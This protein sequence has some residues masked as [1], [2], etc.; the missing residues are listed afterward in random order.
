MSKYEAWVDETLPKHLRLTDSVV[1]IIEN[2]LKT[3]EIDY[4]TVS[5]RTK[6][7]ESILEKIERKAYKDPAKQLTDLTGIRVVGYFESDISK[8]SD[9]IK[10]AFNVDI[11]NSLN[12]DEKLSVNQIGYRSVHFVCDIGQTR[13][14]LPE[15]LNLS[16]LK[17]E[18][19][20]RTVLQHAWAE[21]AHDR[22][23][24]FS[25][26]LP[27]EIER[28]LF[29]YAG[30][31]EIA[32][33]GFNEISKKIDSY[34]EKVQSDTIQ[35]NLDYI[36]D[37]I[38]LPQF[39]ENW[40]KTNGLKLEPLKHKT[41]ISEL[42]SEL[43]SVGINKTSELNQII[44]QDY[45]KRCK[46]RNYTSNIFGHTRSWLIINDWKKLLENHEINWVLDEEEDVIHLFFED[47]EYQEIIRA[48]NTEDDEDEYDWESEN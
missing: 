9:L 35:G 31:L 33:K 16:N 48:F 47:D 43:N 3:H 12:Q 27:K 36:L 34:I 29:L 13:S 32:D 18:I 6:T 8:I 4:L 26:R 22:N 41:E 17:F 45:A 10:S 44:P 5:G 21:L 38:T 40:F 42:I 11:A 30:M 25:G 1:S 15:F 23:Y 20:V 2:L 24:K 7:K 46:D 19:Q 39:I 37:S 14:S 28:N